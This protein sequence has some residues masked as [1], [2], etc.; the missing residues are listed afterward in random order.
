MGKPFKPNP[1]KPW[2]H[3]CLDH[4]PYYKKVIRWARSTNS[5]GGSKTVWLCKVCDKDVRIPNK[6]KAAS[7]LLNIMV[8]LLLLTLAGGYYLADRYLQEDR[9]Q[10]LFASRIVICI[11]LAPLLY[12]HCSHL[13]FMT[14][15]KRWAEKHKSE[16]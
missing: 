8:I 1:D 4:T 11:I 7:W 5:P 6:E 15:W 2:C 10:I 14:R 3:R 13:R 16:D 12:F 9:E